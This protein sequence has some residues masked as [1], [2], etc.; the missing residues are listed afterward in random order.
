MMSIGKDTPQI[1]FIAQA[2]KFMLSFC[3]RQAAEALPRLV[4]FDDIDLSEVCKQS[5][6]SRD[7]PIE[8][9]ENETI[10]PFSGMSGNVRRQSNFDQSMMELHVSGSRAS[11]GRRSTTAGVDDAPSHWGGLDGVQQLNDQRISQTTEE[12]EEFDFEPSDEEGNEGQYDRRITGMGT[13]PQADADGTGINF[14]TTSGSSGSNSSSFSSKWRRLGKKEF[15]FRLNL[16]E[17]HKKW[18]ERAARRYVNKMSVRF[19]CWWYLLHSLQTIQ[20]LP[21]HI[22]FRAFSSLRCMPV[23]QLLISAFSCSL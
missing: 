11:S 6:D 7:R 1:K 22:W 3:L 9:K 18:V 15:S 21:S 4:D 5:N 13:N 23:S 8:A 12:G 10:Q 2:V 20:M 19:K 17:K 16:L 14:N